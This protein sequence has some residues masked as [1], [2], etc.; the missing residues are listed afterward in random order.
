MQTKIQEKMTAY[1]GK[2]S[3]DKRYRG[4]DQG[5]KER[6]KERKEG[7]REEGKVRGREIPFFFR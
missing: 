7:K 6:R 4:K 3:G 1:G 5:K 2:E